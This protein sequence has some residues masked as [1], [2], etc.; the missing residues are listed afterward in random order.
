MKRVL[1]LATLA[2]IACAFAA[3]SSHDVVLR[4]ARSY[5]DGGG[6]NLN[7]RGTGTAEEILFDGKRVLSKGTDGTYCCGFT[8]TVAMKAGSQLDLFK[9]KT[10][11]QIKRFQK[12]WYG[13]VDEP[14]LRE[15]QC[16]LAVVNLGVGK[17]VL[18]D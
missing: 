7:W 3:H 18:F 4:A 1:V 2:T 11:E 6:Y 17:S 8:F 14:E 9:G 16:S 15:K 13:A 5:A 10:L 12:E